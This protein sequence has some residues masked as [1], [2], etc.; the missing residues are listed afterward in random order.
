LN[1]KKLGA[2]VVLIVALIAPIMILAGYVENVLSPWPPHHHNSDLAIQDSCIKENTANLN[3]SL[4]ILSCTDKATP[5][6]AI[7]MEKVAQSSSLG[8][9]VYVNGTSVNYAAST[10]FEIQPGDTA[11]V[12]MIVPY[13]SNPYALATLHSTET[14]GLRVLTDKAMY[15][16]YRDTSGI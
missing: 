3:V 7:E 8:V 12:N 15:G 2:I 14:V 13:V 11:V 1:Q 10:L 5:I 16:F 9:I 6:N 4:T